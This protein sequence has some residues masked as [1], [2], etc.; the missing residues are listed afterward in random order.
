MSIGARFGG[1][2]SDL[3]D[4]PNLLFFWN[5]IIELSLCIF[6]SST[7]QPLTG[8]RGNQ[9]LDHVTQLYYHLPCQCTVYHIN[10][11]HHCIVFHVDVCIATWH[12]FTGPRNDLKMPK[13]GDTWQP[14]VLPRHHDDFMITSS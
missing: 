11:P 6:P 10:M 12:I 4:L 14:L 7:W 2:P 5:F 9:P 3:A 1:V 8:P 13:M